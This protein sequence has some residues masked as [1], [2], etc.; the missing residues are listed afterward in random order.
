MRGL[1]QTAQSICTV[2]QLNDKGVM[3]FCAHCRF[4]VTQEVHQARVAHSDQYTAFVRAKRTAA[5]RK[6][7]TQKEG[8]ED[9]IN[10]GMQPYRC[11]DCSQSSACIGAQ[12]Q[13]IICEVL[14]YHFAHQPSCVSCTC[15][16][17]GARG[18]GCCCSL[19]CDALLPHLPMQGL[20]SVPTEAQAASRAA[21]D[22]VTARPACACCAEAAACDCAGQHTHI[23]GV[24]RDC[25]GKHTDCA[26]LIDHHALGRNLGALCQVDYTQ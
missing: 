22:G 8:G 16:S 23:Q 17:C 6:Y 25:T 24:A 9:D 21:L 10:M 14:A 3:L 18:D 2:R 5:A 20:A 1:P 12:T 11:A 19:H 13:H 26:N 15:C 4:G 7:L